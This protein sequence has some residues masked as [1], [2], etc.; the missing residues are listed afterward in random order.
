[1]GIPKSG[2]KIKNMG[3]EIA[4][5]RKKQKLIAIYHPAYCYQ[6]LTKPKKQGSNKSASF[7]ILE[8]H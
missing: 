3:I 8:V 2:G 5:P 1:M 6:M 7:I 4:K